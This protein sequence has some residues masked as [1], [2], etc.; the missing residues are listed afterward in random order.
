[1]IFCIF[2]HCGDSNRRRNPILT[3]MRSII[4]KLLIAFLLPLYAIAYRKN[5][6]D[7]ETYDCGSTV[8]FHTCDIDRALTRIKR[9][10]K[11]IT[12]QSN[13]LPTLKSKIERTFRDRMVYKGNYFNTNDIYHTKLRSRITAKR[14][15][16]ILANRF[17][18]IAWCSVVDNC[19]IL[20][21]TRKN[22]FI[23]KEYLCRKIMNSS[24]SDKPSV[25]PSAAGSSHS[26]NSDKVDYSPPNSES[27][28]SPRGDS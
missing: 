25:S 16:G 17:D 28:R 14:W 2:Q 22:H 11:K 5:S 27:P 9:R 7:V 6:S 12:K 10:Y 3:K 26:L 4:S 19:K 20:G 24:D 23:R 13:E 1:M 8:K 15:K 18:V 21:I